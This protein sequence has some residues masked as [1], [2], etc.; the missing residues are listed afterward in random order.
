MPDTGFAR[1]PNVVWPHADVLGPIG[2]AVFAALC[3]HADA[4]G[5]CWPSQ[6]TIAKEVRCARGPV[7]DAVNRLEREGLLAVDRSDGLKHRYVILALAGYSSPRTGRAEDSTCSPDEPPTCLPREQVPPT[8]SAREHVPVQQMDNTCSPGEHELDSRTRTSRDCAPPSDDAPRLTLFAPGERNGAGPAAPKPRRCQKPRGS[9]PEAPTT[10][11]MAAYCTAYLR[12]YG[13]EPLRDARANGQMAQIVRRVG[14]EAAPELA[15]FFVGLDD[16]FYIRGQH[17]LGLLLKDLD[18][19][20]TRMLTVG[21]NGAG[22]APVAVNAATP[23]PG[24]DLAAIMRAQL[25]AHR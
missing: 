24:P 6:G 12:R 5:S 10:A 3:R 7:V 13:V 20:R 16:P 23:G 22:A 9:A 17:S 1:V 4:A 25:G 8:C 14:A 2:I 15:A 21:R 11:A 18:A 19:L